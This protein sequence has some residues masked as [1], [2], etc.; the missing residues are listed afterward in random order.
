MGSRVDGWRLRTG[1][2][3]VAIWA[4]ASEGESNMVGMRRRA[5]ALV[6]L[7]A[8]S[9]LLVVG[10]PSAFAAFHGVAQTKQCTSPV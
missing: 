5:R 3:D 7:A 2:P 9:A 8:F 6:V 1:G 10:V 4:S